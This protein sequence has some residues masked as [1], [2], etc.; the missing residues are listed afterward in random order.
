MPS[1]L[2]RFLGS[3]GLF[4]Q[5]VVDCEC[6]SGVWPVEEVHLLAGCDQQQVVTAPVEGVN[7]ASE[8]SGV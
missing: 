5:G 8:L 6:I 2:T 4:E 3:F 7:W 1:G